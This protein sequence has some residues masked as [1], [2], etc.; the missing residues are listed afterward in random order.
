MTSQSVLFPWLQWCNSSTRC[1]IWEIRVL[2][3]NE[4]VKGGIIFS[5]ILLLVHLSPDTQFLLYIN[6]F[7]NVCSMTITYKLTIFFLS[8]VMFGTTKKVPSWWLRPQ[9]V[10]F[11]SIHSDILLQLTILPDQDPVAHLPQCINSVAG[12]FG[13]HPILLTKVGYFHLNFIQ[14]LPF[15]LTNDI[16]RC[17]NCQIRKFWHI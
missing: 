13:F 7:A 11:M 1:V 2:D 12:D 14:S 15:N 10:K 17:L 5:K 4:W 3:I 16:I 9:S 8:S 6:G